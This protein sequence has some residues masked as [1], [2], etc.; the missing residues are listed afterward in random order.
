MLQIELEK[1]LPTPIS[2][3]RTT[4]LC[5]HNIDLIIKRDDLIHPLVSGNKFRKLIPFFNIYDDSNYVCISSIGGMWS[6]HLLACAVSCHSLNIPFTAYVLNRFNAPENEFVQC[7]RNHRAKI[8]FINQEEYASLETN[9]DSNTSHLFIPLGGRQNTDHSGC[10]TIAKEIQNQLDVPP[11]LHLMA[12]GTGTTA[13]GFIKGIDHQCSVAIFPILSDLQTIELIKS[14][15]SENLKVNLLIQNKLKPSFGKSNQEIANFMAQ[16][17]D[18]QDILFDPLYNGKL[19]WNLITYSSD[20]FNSFE[21]PCLIH[22]GGMM[23]WS[24]FR[25]RLKLS[26]KITTYLDTHLKQSSEKLPD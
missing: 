3:L 4:K 12:A 5:E 16:L 21:R 6:N 11:D 15:A 13:Q 23:G 8:I 1:S 9:G 26:N 22:T 24:G 25:N 2:I 20:L 10:M 18:E 19:L 14:A 7:I 17:Y